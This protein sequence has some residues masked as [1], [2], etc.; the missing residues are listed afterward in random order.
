MKT[1]STATMTGTW[2]AS[3]A[4]SMLASQ[5]T[6]TSTM[7]GI[8]LT[9]KAGSMLG[10]AKKMYNYNDRYMISFRGQLYAGS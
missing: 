2:I 7:T 8:W 6:Y 10:A 1:T 4:G 5:K 3:G 9:V